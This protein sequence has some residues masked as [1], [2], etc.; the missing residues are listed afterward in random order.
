MNENPSGRFLKGYESLIVLVAIAA[1]AVAIL[2]QSMGAESAAMARRLAA[3]S[4]VPGAEAPALAPG[5]PLVVEGRVAPETPSGEEGLAIYLRERHRAGA[6]RGDGSGPAGSGTWETD[7]IHAPPFVLES[8]SGPVRIVNAGYRPDIAPHRAEA[9]YQDRRFHGF[10]PGD[11]V[12]VLGTAGEGGIAAES[13]FGGSREEAVRVL[14]GG[15]ADADRWAPVALASAALSAAFLL[16]YWGRV[17]LL[18][19]RERAGT[20]RR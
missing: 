6:R 3:T 19:A 16:G 12:T 14:T 11:G 1:S 17:G 18:W 9:G 13:V 7:S 2:L 5:T 15:S 10:R 20:R 4:A 8:E